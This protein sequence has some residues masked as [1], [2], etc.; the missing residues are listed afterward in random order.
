LNV[1]SRLADIVYSTNIHKDKKKKDPKRSLTIH[2]GNANE[3][4]SNHNASDV[5]IRSQ[6]DLYGVTSPSLGH[7]TTI[8][9][10]SRFI[11]T[12]SPT[13]PR[14]IKLPEPNSMKNSAQKPSHAEHN[15]TTAKQSKQS[16]VSS[17]DVL[18]ELPKSIRNGAQLKRNRFG[19]TIKVKVPGTT[20]EFLMS[21]C[22]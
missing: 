21:D 7:A 19:G 18:T 2:T 12:E 20:D 14:K 4:N 11:M 15:D 3:F 1:T 17:D 10:K 6:T 16:S 22:Q 5:L 9:S 8:L 13:D